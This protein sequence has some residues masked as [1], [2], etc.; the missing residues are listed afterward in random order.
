MDNFQNSVLKEVLHQGK[1]C[2]EYLLAANNLSGKTMV[3]VVCF[4]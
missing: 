3:N 1:V 2:E 4:K